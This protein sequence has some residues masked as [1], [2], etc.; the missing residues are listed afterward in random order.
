MSLRKTPLEFPPSAAA[1]PADDTEA[2]MTPEQLAML[3]E[4]WRRAGD[5]DAYDET[6]TRGEAQKRI[7]AL[8][9]LLEREAHSGRERLPRT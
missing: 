7:V 8:E 6:L 5:T 1:T 2:P 3:K 4:L 9:T